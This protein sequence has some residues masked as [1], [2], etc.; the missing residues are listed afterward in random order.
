MADFQVDDQYFRLPFQRK[1]MRMMRALPFAGFSMPLISIAA[2]TG[3]F[4]AAGPAPSI[5][6]GR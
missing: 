4:I 3:G 1:G 2:M 5:V 6:R